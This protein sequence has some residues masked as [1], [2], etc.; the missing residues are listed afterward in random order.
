MQFGRVYGTGLIILGLILCGLQFAH[1]VAPPKTEVS[2][3][4]ET[5]NVKYPV[6]SSLPGI[7]GA[8]SLVAGIALFVTAPRKDEPEP[9]YKVK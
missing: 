6:R 9:K 1:Y 8:A 7:V 4:T 5:R 2:D 3:Q